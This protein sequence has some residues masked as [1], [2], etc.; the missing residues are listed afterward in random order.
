MGNTVKGG[1][2]QRGE[3]RK[4]EGLGETRSAKRQNEKEEKGGSGER[5]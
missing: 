4:G 2:E 5:A 3:G 1:A